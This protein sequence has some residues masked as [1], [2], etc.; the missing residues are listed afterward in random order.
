MTRTKLQLIAC[1]VV[2]SAIIC[3]LRIHEI[4]TGPFWWSFGS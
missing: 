1:A 2:G 3:K 4:V